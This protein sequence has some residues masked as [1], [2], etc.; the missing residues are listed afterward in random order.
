MKKSQ[1]W[2]KGA[3]RAASLSLSVGVSAPERQPCW[4]NSPAVWAGLEERLH[5]WPGGDRDSGFWRLQ[6]VGIIS[7]PIIEKRA[8][9][10]PLTSFAKL[11]DASLSH[12]VRHRP[13]RVRGREL[14]R[15]PP[16]RPKLTPE[17]DRQGTGTPEQGAGPERSPR[18]AC[19]GVGLTKPSSQA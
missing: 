7:S 8:P 10:G 17:G 9:P 3:P 11:S 4:A 19:S 16:F 13:T 5:G 1:N 14:K 6:Q 15:E 12:P 18:S 2:G